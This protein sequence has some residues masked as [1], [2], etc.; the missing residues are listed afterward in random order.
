[1]FAAA[2]STDA[3]AIAAAG[4]LLGVLIGG[5][6][7]GWLALKAE[8][9]QAKRASEAAWLL[10]RTELG[11]ALDA[12]YEIR[13]TERWPIGWDRAWSATWR[14]SRDKLLASPPGDDDL[15]Q[16]ATVCARI[17]ELQNAVNTGRPEHELNLSAD[18][19]IFLWRMQPL[20]EAACQ[21]LG[22]RSAEERPRD[23]TEEQLMGS[24]EAADESRADAAEEG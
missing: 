6:T 11:N 4:S 12:V 3:A 18:D 13:R 15:H 16:V 7:S 2:T 19:Q 23:L 24:T 10:L 1:V 8:R 20:L 14:D 17:D 22:Y 5:V 9:R 21:A